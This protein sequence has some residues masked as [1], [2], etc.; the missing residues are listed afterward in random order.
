[1][2]KP[3]HISRLTQELAETKAE[4][5][6]LHQHLIHLV[7]YLTSDKFYQD[8]TVQ[9]RDVLNRLTEARAEGWKARMEQERLHAEMY[10][11]QNGG[12]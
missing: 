11:Q 2:P 12:Q 10:R 8:P 6:T 3:N 1:M 7:I 4:L 5:S 9:V